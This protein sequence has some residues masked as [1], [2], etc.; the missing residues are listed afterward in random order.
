MAA[1]VRLEAAVAQ[2]WPVPGAAAELVRA[3]VAAPS[4]VVHAAVVRAAADRAFVAA[5][6]VDRSV[7]DL[8]L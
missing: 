1:R 5:P 6:V 8:G 7:V 2:G 3:V 4:V